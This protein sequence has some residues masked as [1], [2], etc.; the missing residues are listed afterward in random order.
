[1]SNRIE[2]L[3]PRVQ[4]LALALLQACARQGILLRVTQTRRTYAEQAVLY[5][6]G[7]T[8]P[9][10]IVTHAPA[11]YSYHNFGLA[12]DVCQQGPVPYPVDSEFW[13]R[14]GDTG[15][16]LGL[17]W[18]GRWKHPD[19][20]HLEYHAPGETLVAL[21]NKVASGGLVA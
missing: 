17:V 14:I 8:T 3:D 16:S 18:G 20:P 7:R 10:S 21:R 4:P 5:A 19:R 9:G 1:M 15:E 12:F 2:D 11:G 6:Q 13:E